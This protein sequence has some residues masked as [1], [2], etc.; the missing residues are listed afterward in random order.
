[1]L[2]SLQ[3][4][5][6]IF[7]VVLLTG[8]VN[9]PLVQIDAIAAQD[10]QK[11]KTFQIIDANENRS[12]LEFGQYADQ[13]KRVMEEKGFV[14]TAN[15]PDFILSLATLVGPREAMTQSGVMPTYGVT[16]S[17][18]QTTGYV[19]GGTYYGSTTSTPTYGVTGSRAYQQTI[20]FYPIG[21][22]LS[23]WKNQK[24]SEQIW[25]I[26]VTGRAEAPDLRKHF[27]AMLRA[28]SPY[29]SQDTGGVIEIKA[30]K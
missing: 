27:P 8:C 10:A 25:R 30:E 7:V 22:S 4:T 18:T 12:P 11:Y 1:M 16:G 13:V 21:F 28:A 23:A 26:V 2:N 20:N 17:N 3:K 6:T 29:I 9:R 14:Q 15:N 19:A 24:E 5:L